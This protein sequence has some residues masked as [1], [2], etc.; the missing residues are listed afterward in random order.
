M[1]RPRRTA[2]ALASLTAAMLLGGAATGSAP[3]HAASEE[4]PP[5]ELES[6]VGGWR[7]GRLDDRQ[8]EVT[9]AYPKPPV[10]R[11]GQRHRALI[12][13]RIAQAGRERRPGRFIVNG[14]PMPLYTDEQGRFVKPW[15]FGQGS[16]SVE[17]RTPDGRTRTRV[18]FYETSASTT[19]ARLR[20]ILGWD[21]GKAEVDLH[22]VTPDGQ[23]AFWAHPV[24]TNGGGLDV[25]SVDG[26]G[27]EIFSMAAPLRG[28]YLVYVNYWGNFDPAGYTFDPARRERPL[29]TTTVAIVT[30]ENTVDEKR[31]QHVVPLRKIGDTVFVRALRY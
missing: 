6:P 25:D 19:P 1:A 21:D 22:V 24:L 3:R 23:H 9:A 27:P 12:S 16:N 2:T 11:G 14:N 8:A 31:E 18:Q 20:I 7:D 15:A 13:G 10:D 5:I 30:N 28:T 17:V 26:G 29:I 4:P